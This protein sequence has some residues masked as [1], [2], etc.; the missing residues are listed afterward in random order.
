MGLL[1]IVDVW[2]TRRMVYWDSYPKWYRYTYTLYSIS[3]TKA[4]SFYWFL[5]VKK[6]YF[7]SSATFFPKICIFIHLAYSNQNTLQPHPFS[8]W[9]KI[10]TCRICWSY[11]CVPNILAYTR[12]YIKDVFVVVVV[13]VFLHRA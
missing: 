10:K 2:Q 8:A 13:V 12:V 5:Q 7:S 11:F 6:Q 4:F 1:T 9:R 3:I